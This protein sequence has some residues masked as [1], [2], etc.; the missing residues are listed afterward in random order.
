MVERNPTTSWLVVRA[1][2]A[3]ASISESDQ[4]NICNG[5]QRR[6]E[7]VMTHVWVAPMTGPGESPSACAELWTFPAC[8][9]LA[10]AE[11][12]YFFGDDADGAFRDG[13]LAVPTG[14]NVRCSGAGRKEPIT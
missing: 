3:R 7:T 14:P 10:D 13:Q 4:I 1:K 12:V 6:R 11:D 5:L 8:A 2:R 9:A